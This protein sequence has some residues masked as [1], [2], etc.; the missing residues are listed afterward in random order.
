MG[1]CEHSY[2][3]AYR[4]KE[5]CPYCEVERLKEQVRRLM[6]VAQHSHS[7]VKYLAEVGLYD[8]DDAA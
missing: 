8:Q 2:K 1:S 7:E 5:P 4:G 6:E 3:F